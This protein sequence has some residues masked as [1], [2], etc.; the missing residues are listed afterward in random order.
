MGPSRAEERKREEDEGG[1]KG[2]KGRERE[3]ERAEEGAGRLRPDTKT[4]S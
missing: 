3:K 1:A 2:A 4:H